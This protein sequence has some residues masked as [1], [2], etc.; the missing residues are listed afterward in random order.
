[1]RGKCRGEDRQVCRNAQREKAAPASV[2]RYGRTR[3]PKWVKAIGIIQ[4]LKYIYFEFLEKENGHISYGNRQKC[5]LILTIT[6]FMDSLTPRGVSPRG[7]SS[8]CECVGQRLAAGVAAAAVVA[9]IAAAAG[10]A[11]AAAVVAAQKYEDNQDDDPPPVAAKSK[12]AGIAV[13]TRNLP[14]KFKRL[15]SFHVMNCG[16]NGAWLSEKIRQNAACLRGE[17]RG[18][19]NGAV[20]TL[21]RLQTAH[22]ACRTGSPAPPSG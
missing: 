16:R 21:P 11:A 9:A 5:F 14:K 7:V 15:R 3:A 10:I 6:D 8:I 17:R 18:G 13:H 22:P 4:F 19:K 20:R 12:N 1:M 2:H